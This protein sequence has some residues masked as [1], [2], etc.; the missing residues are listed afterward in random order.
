M[1]GAGPDPL[2]VAARRTL[3][4]ALEAMRAHLDAVILV[5]AQ[6]VYVHAGA[7]DVT[8]APYTTD[9]DLALDPSVLGPDPILEDVLRGAGFARGPNPG[10]WAKSAT[11]AGV[12]T[13]VKVDLM[14]PAAVAGAG[15]RSASIPPHDSTSA[16]KTVGLEGALIDQDPHR[17]RAL[18]PGDA[19]SFLIAVA[20]P[21]ALLVAKLTKIQERAESPTRLIDK[22]ALDVLRLLQAVP[23]S[24]LAARLRRLQGAEVSRSVTDRAVESLAGLFGTAGAQGSRMAARAAA[25]MDDEETTAGSV[26]ILA[27]DL[28][29]ALDTDA[30]S[31]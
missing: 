6:A 13:P 10:A 19:R 28:L 17:V 22:D 7:A 15:T 9:A 5:G 2:Y 21:G 31:T 14:V 25:P 11:V 20:G 12:A 30:M 29:E 18:D 23:T 3:L 16:R 27:R 24:E 1:S 8:V 26:S 4:D